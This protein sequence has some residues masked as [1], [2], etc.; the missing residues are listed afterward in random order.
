MKIIRGRKLP[1]EWKLPASLHVHGLKRLT[2]GLYQPVFNSR[3]GSQ[4]DS[5]PLNRLRVTSLVTQP[6]NYQQV[7]HSWPTYVLPPGLC[8]SEPRMEKCHDSAN[9][10]A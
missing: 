7:W 3:H 6:R 8:Q 10:S 5:H 9:L 2:D 4:T 1:S